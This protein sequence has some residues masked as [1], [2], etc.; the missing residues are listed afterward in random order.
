MQDCRPC[1]R[2]DSV[3]TLSRY[4]AY[5]IVFNISQDIVIA[6]GL[7][8]RYY[9]NARTPQRKERSD[10]GISRKRIREDAEG[11]VS[12]NNW[13]KRR[14]VEV[15]VKAK[16]SRETGAKSEI[17]LDASVGVGGWTESHEKEAKFQQQKRMDRFLESHEQGQ[18]LEH[19]CASTELADRAV[20]LKGLC[21]ELRNRKYNETRSRTDRLLRQPVQTTLEGKRVYVQDEIMEHD[22][23][24][25][26]YLL[27]VCKAR[28]ATCRLHAD[29]FIVKD[30]EQPGQRAI[31]CAMLG[32]CAIADVHYLK[33]AGRAGVRIKYKAAIDTPRRFYFSPAFLQMHPTLVNIIHAKAAL[34]TSKWTFIDSRT[35]C[36]VWAVHCNARRRATEVLAFVSEEEAAAQD[37]D[38]AAK[39]WGVIYVASAEHI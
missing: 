22:A 16:A 13:I 31:W 27:G 9:G 30:V 28:T 1:Q 10:A 38:P 21:D 14:R 4:Y 5:V 2:R 29:V 12:L 24:N 8:V 15:D 20:L 3:Y 7:W 18:I 32:G 35:S 34:A 26:R 37:R 23:A 17:S 39:A 25:M 36:V 6:R 33:T 11:K 19:E